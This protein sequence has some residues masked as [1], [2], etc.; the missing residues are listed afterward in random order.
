MC[1][2]LAIPMKRLALIIGGFALAGALATAF[3]GTQKLGP[4]A[5]SLLANSPDG[6]A[7]LA[8]GGGVIARPSKRCGLF[9]AQNF[10]RL[11]AQDA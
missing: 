10:Q 8:L 1:L 3:A 7:F 2:I 9:A 5:L 4:A 6:I 11:F